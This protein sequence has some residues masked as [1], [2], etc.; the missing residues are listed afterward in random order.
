MSEFK[1]FADKIELFPH[2]NA[3]RMQLGRVGT[4][5]VVVGKGLYTSGDVVVFAPKRSILPASVRNYFR[6]VETNQSYLR[7]PNEDRVGSIRLRGEESEGAILPNEWVK[8]Q[9]SGAP[10]PGEDLSE[11]LGI[12]EY[13]PG[14]SGVAGVRTNFYKGGGLVQ[15]VDEAVKME[16]FVRHDVEQFRIFQN[17]FIPGEEVLLTEKIHGSLISILKDKEGRIAVTSK[18]RAE[19]NLVLREYPVPDLW[20]GKNIFQKI[21]NFCKEFFSPK[22]KSRNGYW[23]AAYDSGIIYFLRSPKFNGV[24]VQVIGEVI[25]FQKG[26][27]YGQDNAT[28]LVFRLVE[29][30]FDQPYGKYSSI[31]PF[32]VGVK[33]VPLL[34]KG[35]Y[36]LNKILPLSEGKETVSGNSLHIREGGVL[37]PAVFRKTAKGVPLLVKLLNSKYKQN[38]DDPT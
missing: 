27:S 11:A 3:D 12:S 9:L 29:N 13:I 25:P 10:I 26:F 8:N 5:Q 23:Q 22:K 20:H 17:E 32:E 38:D 19:K 28:V 2:P 35:P 4:Y 37:T 1:V 34:Y 30:T 21:K 18:G 33:W 36:D 6:N 15:K 14:E 7:G 16:R 31:L 24:E